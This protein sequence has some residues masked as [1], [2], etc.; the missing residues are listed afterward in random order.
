MQYLFF[1]YTIFWD[2]EMKKQKNMLIVELWSI[3]TPV[4]LYYFM[5][6]LLVFLLMYICQI[7][8]SESLRQD[9]IQNA[10]IISAGIKALAMITSAG[11]VYLHYHYLVLGNVNK[12]SDNVLLKENLLDKKKIFT[13]AA[14]IKT[15]LL[16]IMGG[17]TLN[18]WFHL[19]GVIQSDESYHQ[20]AE[21][22]FAL[23]VIMG[24]VVYG[25][26]APLAEEGIFRG[27]VYVKLRELYDLKI[28]LI[29]SAVLFGAFH[30]NMVQGV[31][32]T[33]M[34]IVAAWLYEKYK[35]LVAPILFHGGG[36]VAV[37][38]I[39]SVPSWNQAVFSL[40]GGIG[41]FI[42]CIFIFISMGIYQR[43]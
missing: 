13:T 41:S 7:M 43:K 1:K 33:M 38:L 4:L 5:N 12:G 9:V 11:A 36:N 15:I 35:S 23:P 27:I 40:V 32:G 3:V 14:K 19:L 24:I 29:G 31:Y 37:Y 39:V 25:V 16:G 22:Q 30:G 17:L 18:I 10:V 42:A 26:I 34:G 2:G 20:V 8:L 6:N 28:A 21:A